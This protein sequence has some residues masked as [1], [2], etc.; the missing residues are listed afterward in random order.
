MS[1]IHSIPAVIFRLT[2]MPKITCLT[3]GNEMILDHIKPLT[4]G[5]DQKSFLC[6]A[7]EIM[8]TFVFDI[9]GEQKQTAA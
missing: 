4:C 2:S 5:Y 1:R 6:G 7:C 3:C 8:E 9:T